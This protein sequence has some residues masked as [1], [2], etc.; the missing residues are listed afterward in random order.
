MKF[1]EDNSQKTHVEH[2]E[3]GSITISGQAYRTTVL[4]ESHQ[5]TPFSLSSF[6]DIDVEDF[7]SQLAHKPEILIC[8]SGNQ[9]EMVSIKTQAALATFG[10]GCESMDSAAA[11]RTY[12][13]LASE[14]RQVAAIIMSP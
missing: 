1:S 13:L 3:S 11:C 5:V 2:Y 4:L 8:G 12:N 7:L 14:G 6:D 10:V 9:F